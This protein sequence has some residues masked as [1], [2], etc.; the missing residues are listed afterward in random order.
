MKQNPVLKARTTQILHEH[1]KKVQHFL[2]TLLPE[3]SS[4][5]RICKVNVRPLQEKGRELSRHSSNEYL[6][7]D[8]RAA[9]A[10]HGNRIL[11]FFSNINLVETR[12]WKSAGLFPELYQKYG[13][14]AEIASLGK[15]GL[16]ETVTDKLY[17]GTL[18]AMSRLGLPQLLMADSS[19]YDRA[20]QKL[21]HY[22]KDDDH[23][24]TDNNISVQL[25]FPPMCSWLVMTDTVSHAV[26]SGQHS[27]VNTYYV[28][29]RRCKRQD[30]VP[31]NIIAGLTH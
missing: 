3:Y 20:M 17:T 30:L 15:Q 5:W 10:T 6:H 2:G 8:A 11:R 4:D 24:Q 12:V 16:K 14:A 9:G 18:Y 28:K 1:N 22:L 7:I 23:Y 25:D 19:P 29:R 31:Y 27:L 13:D 26:V 21:H